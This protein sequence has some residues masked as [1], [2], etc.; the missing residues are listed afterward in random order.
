MFWSKGSATVDALVHY[1]YFSGRELQ[2]YCRMP[3]V[4]PHKYYNTTVTVVAGRTVQVFISPD[5]TV[6]LRPV[7]TASFYTLS[8]DRIPGSGIAQKI[9]DIERAYLMTLRNLTK[10]LYMASEPIIE[11]DA[12]RL[13]KYHGTEDLTRITP[14]AFYLTDNDMGFSQFPALRPY[15]FPNNAQSYQQV[16]DYFMGLVHLVTN[17]PALLHGTAEGSGAMRTFRGASMYQNNSLK[18]LL[19]S[20]NHIDKGVFK[21]V[22][23]ML[24]NYNM[25]YEKDPAIKGDC[26]VRADGVAGLFAKELE[27]NEAMDILQI[28]GVLAGPLGP[29][30]G[31]PLEWAIK[32]L[33]KAK[34]LPDDVIDQ[35]KIMSP[36]PE[37]SPPGGQQPSGPPATPAGVG[38]P[39][40]N[41]GTPNGVPVQ[42]V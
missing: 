5:P 23:T 15:S 33:F 14:G 12:N 42:Q 36:Q 1:G 21:N 41:P 10:H 32:R 18:T 35:M 38:N 40:P 28:L 20:V 4:D 25:L 34:K 7:H 31:P 2:E 16:L 13:I 39:N 37:Q 27:S 19:G 26:L 6:D 29:T 8:D 30:A 22:A 11:G 9:R 24:Y 17:I 3:G